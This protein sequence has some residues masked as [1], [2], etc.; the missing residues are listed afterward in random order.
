MSG[1]RTAEIDLKRRLAA[2]DPLAERA[3]TDLIRSLAAAGDWGGAVR[4]AREFTGRVREELPGVPV[5]NLERLVERL[6]EESILAADE[7]AS[8]AGGGRQDAPVVERKV[9][10]ILLSNAIHAPSNPEEHRVQS[11]PKRFDQ[12]CAVGSELQD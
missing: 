9:C 7:D 8:V 1:H 11:S 6:R 3:A 2:V 4:A 5:R 10:Q 12:S